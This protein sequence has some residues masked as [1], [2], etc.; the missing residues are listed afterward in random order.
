MNND[1]DGF[2]GH[3]RGASLSRA[4]LSSSTFTPGSPKTPAKRPSVLPGDQRANAG[5]RRG[6]RTAATRRAWIAALRLRRSA[7][8]SRTRRSSRRRRAPGRRSARVVG[9]LAPEVGGEL[10]A[11]EEARRGR[12][13]PAV[14]ERAGARRCSRSATGAAGSSARPSRMPA[15][16]RE[17]TT[18]PPDSICDAVGG[19]RERDL[20]DAGHRERIDSPSTTV[21]TR[22][23]IRAVVRSLRSFMAS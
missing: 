15:T 13:R 19:A 17:P 7:G 12:V 18:R 4:R 3:R 1:E 22:T 6:A 8:R 5:E 21:S 23:A 2:G 9:P 20:A 14:G 11:V 16:S 10:V